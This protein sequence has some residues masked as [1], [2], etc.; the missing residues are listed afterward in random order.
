MILTPM[1]E[2]FLNF[3]LWMTTL[4]TSAFSLN[5]HTISNV[6]WWDL[7]V[8]YFTKAV[9]L[10]CTIITTAG[11][12]I[13][14]RHKIIYEVKKIIAWIKTKIFKTKKRTCKRDQ[15]TGMNTNHDK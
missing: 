8:S 13:I 2:N 3:T 4:L 11:F 14:N 10:S 9:S 5:I 12:I 15:A 1:K 6:I 7:F